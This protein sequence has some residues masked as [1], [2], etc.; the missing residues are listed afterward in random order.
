MSYFK[1]ILVSVDQL[2]NAI[3][4]GNPDN[5]ISARVGFF[6]QTSKSIKFYKIKNASP[7]IGEAFLF[8]LITTYSRMIFLEYLFPSE[9]T[10]SI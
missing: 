4:G 10:F 2:G 9:I 6:S 5:T 1:N 7:V 3:C 8:Y